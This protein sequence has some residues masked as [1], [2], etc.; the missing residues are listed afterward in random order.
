M[1]TKVWKIL[2]TFV[3]ITRLWLYY[4]SCKRVIVTNAFVS[5]QTRLWQLI[6]WHDSYDML[7]T[8]LCYSIWMLIHLRPTTPAP[9][10]THPHPPTPTYILD[11][12]LD[13]LWLQALHENRNFWSF[14]V[15]SSETFVFE[16][17]TPPVPRGPPDVQIVP[18]TIL[19]L[20]LVITSEIEWK[21]N[22][23]NFEMFYPHLPLGAP[24][25][26]NGPQYD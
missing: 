15:K 7:G 8:W 12:Q 13:S 6:Y 3:S 25:C 11:L 5:A 24:R 1:K 23:E 20:F 10:H 16:N 17:F 19:S 2:I 14:Q 9:T 26:S 21:I 4:K 18:N 22:F